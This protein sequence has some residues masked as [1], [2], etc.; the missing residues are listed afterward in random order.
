MDML[1]LD[2][3]SKETTSSSIPLIHLWEAVYIRPSITQSIL[4]ARSW[5]GDLAHKQKE[6]QKS[7]KYKPNRPSAL[8]DKLSIFT[9]QK[10]I[11]QEK[12]I[13]KPQKWKC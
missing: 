8:K 10:T 5:S 4:E 6:R 3:A 11:C 7:M 13:Y 12:Q 9:L 1:N 2:I